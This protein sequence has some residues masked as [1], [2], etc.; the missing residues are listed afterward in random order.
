MDL[1]LLRLLAVGPAFYPFSD[2]G[3]NRVASA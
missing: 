2:H 1:L 3:F